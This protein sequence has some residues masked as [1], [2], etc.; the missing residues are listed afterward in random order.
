MIK[1]LLI[2]PYNGLAETAKNIEVPA[3]IQLDTTVANLD[4]GVMKAKRAEEQGYDVIISR[5]GTAALIQEY[6]S[7]PV[8]HI[9][10]TGYDMLRV[11]TLIS[12]VKS[13]VALVGFKN[14][15]EGSATICNILDFDVKM[16]TIRSSNEVKTNL[17]RLKQEGFT[18]VIG[19]V[20]TVEVAQ[21]LGLRGVLITSGKEAVMNAI[22]EAKRIHHFF[23]RVNYRHHIYKQ[24]FNEMPLPVMLVNE[25]GNVLEQNG[26]FAEVDPAKKLVHVDSFIHLVRRVL[27]QEQTQWEEIECESRIYQLQGFLVSKTER[28]VGIQL[29]ATTYK[30]DGQQVISLMSEPENQPLIGDS[31][32][33][34]ELEEKIG[35][36]A[37]SDEMTF[38]VGEKGTG[39]FTVA[40]QIHLKRF[41]QTAPIVVIQGSLFTNKSFSYLEKILHSLTNGTVIVKNMDLISSEIKKDLIYRLIGLSNRIKVITLQEELRET[42]TVSNYDDEI[43]YLPPLRERKKDI[44]AFIDYYLTEMHMEKGSETVGVNDEAARYLLQYDW[45]GNLPELRSVVKQLSCLT[46][47]YYIDV[48]D[49]K[50]VMNKDNLAN[51]SVESLTIN[52]TLKEM[53]K[54]I[55]Q[56]VLMEENQNQTKAA[57]RL[58]INRSTL[59]R[60]LRDE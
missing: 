19:D 13:G 22:D 36:V 23:R 47:G 49:V 39:K 37:A 33:V 58:G 52:G 5:G 9:E 31:D 45:K 14:I 51:E 57:K 30:P 27:E 10:I 56:Q 20:I 2:A 25:E 7:I 60:K 21:R 46:R 59:W 4:E 38:L 24:A 42:D 44:L 6:V 3:D 35:H 32:R 55:I 43:I 53:E 28:I 16:V 41:D 1:V 48:S 15:S 18:V 29:N 26:S 8:V 50:K 17:E 34:H 12:G 40:K 54:Q 11:F